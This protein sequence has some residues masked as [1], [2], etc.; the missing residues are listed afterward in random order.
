M[1]DHEFTIFHFFAG[2][3]GKGLGAAKSAAER[4]GHRATF[5]TIG[6][7]DIDPL[8][9]RDFTMLVGAPCHQAD[10][11]TMQPADLIRFAGEKAPDAIMLSPP[12]K[13]LS[14]LLSSK[15]ALEERYQEMNQLMLRALFLACATWTPPPPLIFV[16]NVPR[17]ASRGRIIVEHTKALL[18]AHGYVVTTGNHDC[19]EIGGLA[20]HRRRWVLVAR[21]VAQVPGLLYQPT[22]HRVRACGEVLGPLPLP[23]DVE[24]AGPM[25]S[26]P[27]LSLRN[28]L[29]LALIPPG[30]DWRDLAGVLA[31][32]EKRRELFRRLPVTAWDDPAETV[33]GPGGSSSTN[34]AD[35]RFG[36]VERVAGWADAMGAVTSSPAPSSGAG[37]VADPRWNDSLGVTPWTEPGA[38]VTGEA[39]PSNGRNAVA[40]PRPRGWFPSAYR[41]GSWDATANVVTSGGH[42]ST[43][44]PV[45][46]DPRLAKLAFRKKMRPST[47]G[48]VGWMD[49]AGAITGSFSID[50]GRAAIADP[51]LAELALAENPGRHWNK[52]TVTDWDAAA[53]TVTGGDA[54]VGS[55]APSVADARLARLADIIQPPKKKRNDDLGVTGFDQAASTVTGDARPRKGRFSVADSRFDQ[56]KKKN[57]QRVAG[58]VAW[59]S[60]AETVTSTAKIH[61]GAFQVADPRIVERLNYR[62]LTLDE[63]IDLD[64][65]LDK[66][67]PFIPVIVAADGTWHRPLTTL[68]L[69]VLQSFPWIFNGAPLKLAGKSHTRWR[70]GIGNAVPPDAATEVGNQ[71]LDTL[72]IAKLGLWTLD[73]GAIWVSPQHTAMVA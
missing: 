71:L 25:H 7:V 48:V 47:Y 8:A 68:E 19:G 34:I 51:R 43:G 16:E 70:L 37:A 66:S 24:A 31:E 20:Q 29:R 4:A 6:G 57:W 60:P 55:G 9:C 10:V 27:K 33:T 36:H 56:G 38:A 2:I 18:E 52:Y 65:P 23:G 59:T 67:P 50:N 32:H 58:V 13:G 39:F 54:R 41:V 35:A 21:H 1:S 11:H 3:G 63:A 53:L 62:L 73:T 61:S 26:V 64:L 72:L 30:G 49:P 69:A 22:K 28:W 40:D 44:A 42:P 46:A 15:K 45:V 12:C 17:M 14:A 5:S